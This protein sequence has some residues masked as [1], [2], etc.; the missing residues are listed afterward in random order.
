MRQAKVDRMV[1]QSTT[2][3]STDAMTEHYSHVDPQEK[4]EAASKLLSLVG[5]VGESS[6][7]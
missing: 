4:K 5:M 7:G 1:L 6:S 3:H 2:G